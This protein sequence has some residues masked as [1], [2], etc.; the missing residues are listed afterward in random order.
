MKAASFLK[1]FKSIIEKTG[2]NFV[3]VCHLVD[4]KLLLDNRKA[5]PNSASAKDPN[6]SLIRQTITYL[7]VGTFMSLMFFKSNDLFLISF[8]TH[9]YLMVMV[10]ITMLAEYSVTLFD[11]RDNTLLIPLPVNGQT[12][13]WSRVLHIMIYLLLLTGSLA[14]P[15]VVI[16]HIKFGAIAGLMLI[17]S[18][19][20]NTIFTLFFTLFI[21]L[22]LMKFTSG[23][24]LKDIMMYIQVGFTVVIMVG[25]QFVPRLVIPMSLNGEMIQPHWYFLLIPPAWFSMLIS[26]LQSQSVIIVSGAVLGIV[27]PIV[28]MLFIGKKLFYG[29][30]KK[31]TQLNTGDNSSKR[32]KEGKTA[33]ENG[34]WFRTVSLVLGIPKNEIPV[35]R[36]M[37]KLSGRERLFKQSLLPMIAYMVV[38]PLFSVFTKNDMRSFE[39]KYLTFIYFT[40]MTS[41]MIPNVI[42][43]GNANHTSWIYR[44]IPNL[45]PSAIMS[46][47]VKAS[48]GKYF[49]PIFTVMVLPLVYVKGAMALVDVLAV[50]LFNYLVVLATLYFQRPLMPFSQTKTAAQGGKTALRMFLIIFMALPIG[51]LHSYLSGKNSW[52][53][54]ILPAIY[55]PFLFLFDKLWYPKKLNWKMVD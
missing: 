28:S 30:D 51:F 14:L 21:Y 3:Q 47:A 29:F 4:L 54:I 48:F 32:M 15:S 1:P 53:P 52:Y 34:I 17:V 6:N 11:T 25:Y 50:L 45:K 49:L 12:L 33:K 8:S 24:K 43:I 22:G 37:W 40:I 20:L 35:F 5:R 55:L 46:N 19:V 10:T 2:A 23:D 36:L 42:G 7:V 26:V 44:I 41:S 9:I 39:S 38:I 13:G 16:T 31:L 27:F 18:T